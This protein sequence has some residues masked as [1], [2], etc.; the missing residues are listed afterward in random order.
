VLTLPSLQVMSQLRQFSA[1]SLFYP[2]YSVKTLELKGD[3][4]MWTNDIREYFLVSGF[5]AAFD[6]ITKNR[7]P[8][9]TTDY[10]APQPEEKVKPKAK[11]NQPEDAAET[12]DPPKIVDLDVRYKA[13]VSQARYSIHRSLG[14]SIKKEV[15]KMG[16]PTGS[17]VELWTA[18]RSCF[19]L[20]DESTVQQLR[21]DIVGWDVDKA[22]SWHAFVEGLGYYK[23]F[24]FLHP[25]PRFIKTKLNK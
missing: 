17:V 1:V 20:L 2:E 8:E 13:I 9:L 14:E 18:V 11:K 16:L 5:P 23:V 21:D 24:F 19:F 22:G 7:M 12:D 6:A 25:E 4:E 15:A 3:Y 10:V